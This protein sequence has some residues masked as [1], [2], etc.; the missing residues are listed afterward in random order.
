MAGIPLMLMGRLTQIKDLF[1]G[2]TNRAFPPGAVDT[3]DGPTDDAIY[4]AF[5]PS[6]LYKPPFGLPR[7]V[8]IVE[9]RRLARSPTPNM[10]ITT[11]I[12]EVMAVP[13]E[14]R[15]KGENFSQS[16]VDEVKAFFDNPNKNME[17]WGYITKSWLKD[18]LEI[19]AGTLVKVFNRAGK[20]VEIYARDGGTFVLNPTIYGILGTRAELL[21]DVRSLADPNNPAYQDFVKKRAAY[22]QFPWIGPAA[23]A[24]PFG[25]REI[26]YVK[27][28]PRTD[29]I[30]GMAPMEILA[31]VVQMLIFG[32]DHNL[33]YFTDNEIP[34]GVFEMI[35]ANTDDLKRFK[36]GMR[37]RIMG[38]DAVGNIR[39]LWWNMP[40]IN[41]E[42]KFVRFQ[43]S[44]AE[45]ELLE[46]QR[47]FSKLVWAV[48]GVTPSELG[49]TE[50]SNRATEFM[51]SRVFRKKAIRPILRLIEYHV[52]TEIITEFGYDDV[53]YGYKEYDIEEDMLRH[54]VYRTQLMVGLK[55]INEIRTENLGLEEVEWGN[56]PFK[57]TGG[58]GG[59]GSPGIGSGPPPGFGKP[60]FAAGKSIP[61]AK[62][63]EKIEGKPFGPYKNFQDC[64]NKNRDKKD[65]DAYCATIKR[66][67]EGKGNLDFQTFE[68]CVRVN[69]GIEA[70]PEG[71]CRKVMGANKTYHK[72]KKKGLDTNINLGSE[73]K[74]VVSPNALKASRIRG[75]PLVLGD[76]EVPDNPERLE[77]AIR[78]LLDEK[79]KEILK[80]IKES[81]IDRTLDKIKALDP[82]IID[83][84]KGILS[85]FGVKVVADSVIRTAFLKGVE[86]AEEEIDTNFIPDKGAIDFL[87]S[88]TFDN[89]K[90][91]TEEISNDLR[92]VIERGLLEGKGP[93][94]L[95]QEVSKIF[96]RSDARAGAIAQTEFN[97]AFNAGHQ[98]SYEQVRVPGKK[99]WVAK[100]DSR[101]TSLCKR[102]DGQEVAV[103]GRFDDPEFR[104]FHPPAHVNCRS[105]IVFVQE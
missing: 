56:E 71:Y 89:I 52:N 18:V 54:N 88:H 105:R 102:L 95:K 7:M 96:D 97:R 90:D 94:A 20:M 16:H 41:T 26:V 27:R 70:D 37:K 79:K 22:F 67:V 42:G 104:G 86:M 66:Q 47:W 101:T 5:I 92:Q 64:V 87:Q 65:P 6:F 84:I 11:I 48:F 72:P 15:G 85:A 32:I 58:T 13:W 69:T 4:K 17:S 49:F 78:F 1:V 29:S 9:L 8:D 51:Q 62:P 68:E 82:G 57:F 53:E 31:K 61:A 55:T 24:V 98:K 59:S 25:W 30:Y 34:K 23:M 21:P 50:D 10:A 14:I 76:N 81:E 91:M 60:S 99:K 77:R 103:D 80:L 46:Q 44:N 74:S 73:N 35:G 63:S 12:D 40:V 83:K 100:I 43:F 2:L 45:L 38:K 33:E 36:E 75:N 93:Q 28:N 19:D 3:A 39:K